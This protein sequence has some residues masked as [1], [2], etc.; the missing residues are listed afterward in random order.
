[1]LSE[2]LQT[3]PERV[4]SALNTHL[5][6]QNFKEFL[7]DFI[8]KNCAQDESQVAVVGHSQHFSYLTATRWPLLDSS[9]E[10]ESEGPC[11]GPIGY[12]YTQAP[13]DYKF[14]SNC[15]FY[16]LDRHLDEDSDRV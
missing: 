14:L 10:E 15:E 8:E 4:E 3:Y 12:D 11:A 9:F 2:I 6:C 5:R 7:R 1:M 13:I 16:P